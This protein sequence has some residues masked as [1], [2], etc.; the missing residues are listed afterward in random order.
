MSD[1]IKAFDMALPLIEE[2]TKQ[3]ILIEIDSESFDAFK[4]WCDVVDKLIL[5]A[6]PKS[7]EVS[8][9]GSMDIL[10]T[11]DISYLEIEDLDSTIIHLISNIKGVKVSRNKSNSIDFT[12]I[13]PSIWRAI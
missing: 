9:D 4:H 8:I 1:F 12:I 2:E 11:L 6:D 7:V 5:S 3:S 13:F 10:F